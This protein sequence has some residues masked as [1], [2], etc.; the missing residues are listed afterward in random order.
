MSLSPD[1]H[2]NGDLSIMAIL[3]SDIFTDN[4][5]ILNDTYRLPDPKRGGVLNETP[6]N[7]NFLSPL[8]FRFILK[9][10]PHV[11]FFIQ[12]V[13]LPGIALEP[14]VWSNP[15]VKVPEPGEHLTYEPLKIVFKVDEDL[16]NYLE[17]HRWLKDLGKPKNFEEYQEL[18]VEQPQF[19]GLGVK[20]DITIIIMSNIKNPNFG[21]TFNDAF[22]IA[23]SQLAFDT[24]Q[25]DINYLV[26]EA[27]FRYVYYDIARA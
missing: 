12:K 18:A 1:I 21:V 16:R 22:P 27:T 5:V 11:E 6:I 7:H 24:T 26:A 19:T 20:S 8:N 2:L 25:E 13:N 10:A 3:G 9:R 23:L 17:I 4:E 15:F 14:P